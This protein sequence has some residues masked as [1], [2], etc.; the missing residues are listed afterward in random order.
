MAA[1]LRTMRATI[2]KVKEPGFQCAEEPGWFNVSRYASLKPPIP[3][4]GSRAEASTRPDAKSTNVLA[5]AE[6]WEA[7]VG[8]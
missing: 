3:P 2:T 1:N 8:R 5:V 6:K 7:W 4:V